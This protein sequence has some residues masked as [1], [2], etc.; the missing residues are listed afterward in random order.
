MLFHSSQL[1]SEYYF[2]PIE[3]K[4]NFLKQT[5]Y[6]PL[7]RLH[8]FIYIYF[9]TKTRTE[10]PNDIP[11]FMFSFTMLLLLLFRFQMLFMIAHDNQN[12]YFVFQMIL[13][14]AMFQPVQQN[15]TNSNSVHSN[16]PFGSELCV[17][18]RNKYAIK[19]M[20][21]IQRITFVRFFGIQQHIYKKNNSIQQ[22]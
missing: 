9:S 11:R 17:S 20:L 6:R 3:N 8:Q 16:N 22:F 12:A 14:Y 1:L 19:H 18:Y 4:I 10:Y 15:F 21:V 7:R 13:H 5:T 2:I